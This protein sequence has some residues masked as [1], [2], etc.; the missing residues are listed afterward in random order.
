MA[1]LPTLC[2]RP[3]DKLNSSDIE[4]ENLVKDK[5]RLQ[6]FKSILAS[7]F[8]NSQRLEKLIN[9]VLDVSRIESD[10]LHLQKEYFNLNEKI[11]N[12]LKDIH[13]KDTTINALP[14]SLHKNVNIEF[15]SS[16]DPI[17]VFADKIRMFEVLSNLITNAI[18]FSNEKPIT[19]SVKKIQQNAVESKYQQNKG[20]ELSLDDTQ[21]N[22]E[23]LTIMMALV[24]VRDRGN[25]IDSDI[26]P[27]LFTKFTT[28]SDQGNGLGLYI[29]KSIIEAHGGQI[30]ALNYYSVDS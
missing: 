20:K 15:E 3:S 11:K 2:E 21:K 19:I 5:D 13:S 30:W 22:K 6:Q 4:F 23:E 28:K 7:T 27:R 26:L 10:K 18:K 25:G 29:T 12:V 17:T 14:S 1:Y 9:N 8:R 24:T 16:E